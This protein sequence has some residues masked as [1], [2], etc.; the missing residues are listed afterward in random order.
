RVLL[1]AGDFV[2][3]GGMDVANYALAMFFA[4]ECCNVHLVT[5]R[6]DESLARHPRVTLHRIPKPGRSYLLGG[7]LLA[8]AGRFWARRGEEESGRTIVNGGNCDVADVNWVHYVHAADEVGTGRRL[9]R[10]VS[11]AW[12]LSAERRIVRRARLVIANSQRTRRDLI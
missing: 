3:T 11:R 10:T 9:R 5:H 4:R 8:A 2:Q 12:Y 1:V 6:A 7:P